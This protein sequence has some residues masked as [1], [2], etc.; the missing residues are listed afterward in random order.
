[1]NEKFYVRLIAFVSTPRLMI[2]L[3]TFK[4]VMVADGV[5]QA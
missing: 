5:C 4:A 2:V 3:S 1:M